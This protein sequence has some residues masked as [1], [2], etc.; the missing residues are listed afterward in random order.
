MRNY[1]KGFLVSKELV[2]RSPPKKTKKKKKRNIN[3]W[4][5]RTMHT[6][7]ANKS[8]MGGTPTDYYSNGSPI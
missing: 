4:K 1:H 2:H 7:A 6:K 5:R 3:S 8:T